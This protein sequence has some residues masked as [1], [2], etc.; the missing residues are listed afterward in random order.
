MARRRE[1]IVLELKKLRQELKQADA[2]HAER[3]RA[4]INEVLDER[5]E[6]KG[7]HKADCG[8][9]ECWAH[10]ASVLSARKLGECVDPRDRATEG[11]W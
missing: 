1:Q 2:E 6:Q 7:A 4:R 5:L 8:C 10:V 3:K 9:H 11:Q